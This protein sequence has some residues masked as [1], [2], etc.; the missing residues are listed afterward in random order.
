[1]GQVQFTITFDC[2]MDTST[3]ALVAFGPAEPYTDHQ[4]NG[5]WQNARTWVGTFNI[6]PLT[7]DGWHTIYVGNARGEEHY[8]PITNLYL[9][10]F[11]IVTSGTTAMTLQATSGPGHVDLSWTQ[12]SFEL[13]AGYNV[14]RAGTLSGAYSRINTNLI[15]DQA[16]AYRDS[17]VQMNV[18]YY[19][20]FTV[21]KTD[22][23]ES[24]PSNIASAAATAAAPTIS[25]TAVTLI[26]TNSAQSGGN[27]TS[28]GGAAIASRGVCWSTS[29]NPT[30]A[31]TKTTNGTGT[32]SFTSNMTG[33]SSGTAYHVRAYATNGAG[34]TGYGNDISF[35]TSYTSTLFVSSDGNC[36]T[37]D[38]CYS[39]IQ[40]AINVAA[41][42]SAIL[43]KQ[44]T[45]AESLSLGS[46]K[47]LL[48]K[49]GYNTTTYTQQI[50]NTTIIQAPGPTSI[51]ASSGSLK[52]QMINM[53]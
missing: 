21:V 11:E 44:G 37:K 14:Y 38:P 50:P 52:F 39:K 16:K 7:G 8:M 17:D 34:K 10:K 9:H 20:K 42:G 2:D 19:Y 6:T 24:D 43:V 33:L 48:I 35:E 41:T 32:G 29:A 25:T 30:T 4:I 5:T 12:D 26:T 22:M 40:D 31:N 28:D 49:G 15:P 23:A 13:L 53:K 51:K 27:I 45:Y 3:Q 46:N 1:M 47:T 36:G 18:S